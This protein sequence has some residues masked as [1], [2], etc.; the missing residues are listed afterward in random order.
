MIIP[1]AAASTSEAL[2]EIE[3]LAMND[4]SPGSTKCLGCVGIVITPAAKA[5]IAAKLMCPNEITPELP[6]K[7]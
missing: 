7:M 2:L 3:W 4:H 6:T 5:P 1:S